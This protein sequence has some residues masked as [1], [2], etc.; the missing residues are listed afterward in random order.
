MACAE[1]VSLIKKGAAI[2]NQWRKDNPGV[3]PDLY[4]ANLK[5]L[6]CTGMDLSRALL[7]V[8]ILNKANFS[9][10]NLRQANL[11]S[12]NLTEAVLSRA[13]LQGAD[14]RGTNLSRVDL[15][16]AVLTDVDLRSA[17]LVGA[18]FRETDLRGANLSSTLLQMAQ[19]LELTQ[20]ASART[21]WLAELGER[22]DMVR[23]D[24]PHLLERPFK[25][26]RSSS[27]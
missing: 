27:F 1:H 8:A 11:S 9:G 22:M 7:S 26:C 3:Q 19:N 5:G 18:N 24:C 12:A 14:C 21:L 20:L 15:C 13:L 17:L 25:G 16:G 2:W 23:Q 10:A 6:I 4:A